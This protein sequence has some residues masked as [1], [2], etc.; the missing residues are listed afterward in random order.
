MVD[1][2][3]VRHAQSANNAKPEHERVEDPGLTEIGYRQADHLARAITQLELDRVITSPFRRTLETTAAIA[4]VN[5]IDPEIWVDLHEQGGCYAGHNDATVVG[6]PGMTRSEIARHFP[7]YQLPPDIDEQGWWRSRPYESFDN[8][9]ARAQRLLNRAQTELPGNV[10]RIAFIMHA[11]FKMLIMAQIDHR[12]L[13]VPYNA[14][15]THLRVDPTQ[16]RLV[17]YNQVAH[18]PESLRTW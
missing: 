4:K 1:L 13:D 16:V 12:A 9:I 14:S 10:Q 6:R 11:D 15:I 7:R 17:S 2:Y 8:A 3:L 18:L 5:S